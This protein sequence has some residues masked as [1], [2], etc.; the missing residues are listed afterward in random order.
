MLVELRPWKGG[1]ERRDTLPN[2]RLYTFNLFH[3]DIGGED[4][5]SDT[6]WRQR[7]FKDGCR[8]V[9]FNTFYESG[10][11]PALWSL[12]IDWHLSLGEWKR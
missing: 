9:I 7:Y 11:L 8:P 3:T 12:D 5:T 4:F 1:T 6:R 10:F 2:I